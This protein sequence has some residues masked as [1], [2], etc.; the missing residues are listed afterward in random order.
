MAIINR[1]RVLL[2]GHPTTVISELD[3]R[4][5]QKEV[6]REETASYQ[7]NMPVLSTR[8]VAGRTLIHVLGDLSPG[9]GFRRADTD[10]EDVYFA[11]LRQ[12]RAPADRSRAINAAGG[13]MND[14]DKRLT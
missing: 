10:L 2:T 3:G 14:E 4:V 12:A 13:E 9:E 1:G 7:A 8:L 11:A 6:D 5:W